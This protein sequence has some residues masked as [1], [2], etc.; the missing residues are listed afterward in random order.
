[1]LELGNFVLSTPALALPTNLY[2]VRHLTRDMFDKVLDPSRTIMEVYYEDMLENLDIL[3]Q[4]PMSFKK[5]CNLEG[6]PLWLALQEDRYFVNNEELTHI[7]SDTQVSCCN[8]GGVARLSISAIPEMQRISDSEAMVCPVDHFVL[9]GSERRRSKSLERTRKYFAHLQGKC[10]NLL[11]SCV[12]TGQER[13]DYSESKGVV[14]VSGVIQ[15]NLDSLPKA[16]DDVAVY[17]RGS[18]DLQAS[19]KLLLQGKL[20][21]L[22]GTFILQQSE[23]GFALQLPPDFVPSLATTTI[24]KWIDLN[25]RQYESDSTK[26]C[27]HCTCPGCQFMK[28]YVHHLFV[29]HEMLGPATLTIHNLHQVM[30]LL[31]SIQ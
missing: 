17:V 18:L 26:L 31:S 24:I 3:K 27:E 1:M 7:N 19:V 16:N 29:V 9:S 5:Y 12:M 11:K 15:D 30:L 21:I 22:D 20:D 14:V 6:Y 13:L 2:S 4:L 10:K 8:H 25:D 23:K 28:S